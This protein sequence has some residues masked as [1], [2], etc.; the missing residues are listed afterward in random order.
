MEGPNLLGWL[1]A[2]VPRLKRKKLLPI[3]SNHN[4]PFTF[5]SSCL[6]SFYSIW[7]M[8]HFSHTYKLYPQIN[9]LLSYLASVVPAHLIWSSLET[10]RTRSSTRKLFQLRYFKLFYDVSITKTIRAQGYQSLAG[11]NSL[12]FTFHL[13]L[14]LNY[15]RL[16][17]EITKSSKI[18]TVWITKLTCSS[19]T[20]PGINCACP[21]L[22]LT[23]SC[24]LYT[25]PSPRD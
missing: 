22:S 21:S 1:H 11:I 24:L 23:N 3:T 19:E 15:S 25:S 9:M 16:I 13:L 14:E 7:P 12:R 20:P 8:Q 2:A 5:R 6:L 18:I 10:I 4:L 17:K